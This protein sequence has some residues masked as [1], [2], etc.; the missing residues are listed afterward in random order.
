M[1]DRLI[2][3]VKIKIKRRGFV[4][5]TYKQHRGISADIL[6][7]KWGVRLD[8]AKQT[9]QSTNQDT[10]RSALKILTRRYRTYFLP[11]RLHRLNCRFYTDT[12][13]A[14]EKSIV[15]NTCAQIFTY[16]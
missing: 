2:R 16:A 9:L 5:Y 4:T 7:R 11:Q 8:K 1:L 6:V 14:K 12:L 10:V 3:K 13:F 15:G